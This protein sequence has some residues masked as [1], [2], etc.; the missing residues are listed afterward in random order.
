MFIVVAPSITIRECV[1]KSFEMPHDHFMEYYG[2]KARFLYTTAQNC[3]ISMLLQV[4]V[5]SM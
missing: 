1:K 4:L 5:I 3:K 2:K